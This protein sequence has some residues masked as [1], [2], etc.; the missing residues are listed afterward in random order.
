MRNFGSALL[1]TAVAVLQAL[2]FS[3]IPG[4]VPWYHTPVAQPR[5]LPSQQ[6]EYIDLCP[7]ALSIGLG[8]DKS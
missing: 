6:Q 1:V 8:D 2:N 7:G 5:R 3:T 4:S